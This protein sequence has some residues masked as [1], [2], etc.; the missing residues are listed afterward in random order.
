MCVGSLFFLPTHTFWL[1]IHYKPFSVC[2]VESLFCV[3]T[4][5]HLD[6][7]G[8]IQAGMRIQPLLVCT[9]Y[10]YLI[11]IQYVIGVVTHEFAVFRYK[12]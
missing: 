1:C 4:V 10:Q 5:V 8:I 11:I 2:W 12:C 7:L 3:S 9:A 6:G